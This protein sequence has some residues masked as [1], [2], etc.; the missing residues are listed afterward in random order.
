MSG[1]KKIKTA[2]ISVYNKE[3]LAPLIKKLNQLSIQIYSTGG[4]KK[5]IEHIPPAILKIVREVDSKL[6]KYHPRIYSID[7]VYDPEGRPWIMELE[8]I[9]GVSYYDN[10]L[11]VRKKF[12]NNMLKAFKE[13]PKFIPEQEVEELGILV[14]QEN[15]ENKEKSEE[16]EESEE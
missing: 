3:N 2:L 12:I 5:F 16:L 15:K 7:F 6:E 10:A 13:A 8:T 9:P 4:T 14:K 11:N 1:L